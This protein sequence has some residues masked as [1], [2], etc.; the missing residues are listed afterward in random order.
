M[1]RYTAAFYYEALDMSKEKEGS[2]K[3]FLEHI[4]QWHAHAVAQAGHLM[5]IPEGTETHFQSE[6]SS[7]TKAITLTG[8]MRWAFILGIVT[9]T[10]LFD[11][12]P[13]EIITEEIP[14]G[15][16]PNNVTPITTH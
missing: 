10:S 16:E 8:D 5:E 12:L 4:Q 2:F 7:E 15:E 11:E 6:H 9:A 3:D 1:S 13:F 14:D